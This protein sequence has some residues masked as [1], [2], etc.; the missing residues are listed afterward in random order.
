MR[1]RQRSE[2][3]DSTMMP[4]MPPVQNR[5]MNDLL[6][7]LRI[8]EDPDAYKAKIAELSQ[9]IAASEKA[10]ADA[11]AV[12]AESRTAKAEAER[13]LTEA[14]AKSDEALRAK[15]ASDAREVELKGREAEI[16]SRERAH[17]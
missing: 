12:I 9:A 1:R 7:L 16:S 5:A 11:A 17:S 13:L 3:G 8:I 2:E 14:K 15:E 6:D 4:T 10:Q